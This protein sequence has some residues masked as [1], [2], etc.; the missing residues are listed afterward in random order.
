[1]GWGGGGAVLDRM[2]VRQGRRGNTCATHCGSAH[3]D[4]A[5]AIWKHAHQAEQGVPTLNSPEPMHTMVL[6]L[7]VMKTL[8]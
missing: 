3:T 4:A 1:M 2:L 5:L 8:L 7:P 6:P